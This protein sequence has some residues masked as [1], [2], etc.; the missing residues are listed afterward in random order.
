[1][2]KLNTSSDSDGSILKN[3]W[4]PF[5]FFDD[6]YDPGKW[7][8]QPGTTTTYIYSGLTETQDEFVVDVKGFSKDEL[9]I[10]FEDDHLTIKGEDKKIAGLTY[11]VNY[12]QYIYSKNKIKEINVLVENGLAHV[13]LIKENKP[14]TKIIVK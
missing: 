3:Y 1:M 6:Q 11:S 8:V 12:S 2:I 5:P 4:S 10:N 14:K 9:D 7:T 13:S